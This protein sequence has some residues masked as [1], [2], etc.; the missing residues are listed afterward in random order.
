MH[1]DRGDS[2]TAGK[3]VRNDMIKKGGS[4]FA[5]NFDYDKKLGQHVSQEIHKSKEELCL[6]TLLCT[7]SCLNVPLHFKFVYF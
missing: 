1:Q 3:T 2:E 4:D 5:L 6:L 7:R